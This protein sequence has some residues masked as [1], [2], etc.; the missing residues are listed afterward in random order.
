[1][2]TFRAD[3]YEARMEK[4]RKKYGHTNKISKI[5]HGQL[6]D[7]TYHKDVVMS[8]AV[9]WKGIPRIKEP[10]LSIPIPRMDFIIGKEVETMVFNDT[11]KGDIYT[12]DLS[13]VQHAMCKHTEGQEEQWYFPVS[14]A[15]KSK[16]KK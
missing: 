1:M 13:E 3:D 12:F 10:C 2:T 11:F 15:K 4:T 14:L 16:K 9:L 7:K 6:K 5:N 8:K